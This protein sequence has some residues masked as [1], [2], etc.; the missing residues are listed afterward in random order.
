MTAENYITMAD[1]LRI[2][3][4]CRATIYNLIHGCVIVLI[5]QAFHF[6]SLVAA[7]VWLTGL[8]NHHTGNNIRSGYIGNIKGLDPH[9]R[10]Q[11]QHFSKNRQRCA[12][13]L[14]LPCYPL[15]FL[16]RVFTGQFHQANV[17]PSLGHQQLW[18]PSQLLL[19]G[20]S[21]W[22]ET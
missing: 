18:K 12:D 8:E 15:C 10:R 9:R 2:M 11:H 16:L 20:K 5:V 6:K 13:A 22:L 19:H 17:I 21:P 14:I 1:V 4:C 7:F 3:R